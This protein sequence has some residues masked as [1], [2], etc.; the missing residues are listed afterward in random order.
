[1]LTVTDAGLTPLLGLTWSQLP[2]EAEAVARKFLAMAEGRNSVWLADGLP[3][4]D[5]KLS[6]VGLGEMLLKVEVPTVR[7]T[8]M[9]SEVSPLTTLMDPGRYRRKDRRG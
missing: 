3:I 7:V 9:L 2:P 8:G 4:W 1:M 5:W 6:E